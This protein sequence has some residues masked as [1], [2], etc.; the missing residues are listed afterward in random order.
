MLISLSWLKKYVRIPEDTRVLVDKLTMTGLNVERVLPTGFTDPNVVVGRVVGVSD[1]PNADKLRVCRVDAGG[2]APRDIVCG[3]ENVAEGQNVLVALPGAKLADGTRIK[4]AKIRGVRSDGMICSE[5]ELGLGDDAAG[6]MVLEGEYVPGAPVSEVLPPPDEILEIEVTPNRPD[7]LCH[8]GV[9]REVAAIERS[10]LELPKVKTSSS[11]GKAPFKVTIEKPEDCPRYVGKL[12]RGIRVGPSPMWLQSSLEGVGLNSV[13]NIVDVAN[14]VMLEMGQPL[15]AFDIKQIR[16]S[17]IVV[18]RARDGEALLALDGKNYELTA[19]TLVIADARQP[20]ALAGVIGGELS[21]VHGD[22]VDILIESANFDTTVVRRGRKG[23]GITTDASY[24]FER[25]VNRD[26]CLRAAERAADLICELAGGEAGPVVD[27]YPAPLAAKT[28]DIRRDRTRRILGADLTAAEIDEHLTALGFETVARS[29][30]KLSILVPSFRLDIEEEIDLIEEVARLYGYDQIGKAWKFR[31][32]T[33]AENPP[34][35]QFVEDL[36]DHMAARGYCEVATSSF[37][38]GREI[39]D[40]AWPEDDPRRTPIPIRNPLNVHHRYLRTSLLPGMLDVIRWNIDHGVRRL[41]LFQAG[42]V[43]LAPRGT[44]QLPEEQALLGLAVSYPNTADFWNNLK[45]APDLFDIKE[46]LEVFLRSFNIDFGAGLQYGFD[47]ATGQFRYR[48]KN[49]TLIEG[50]VVNEQVSRRYDFEQP[51][52]YASLDLVRLFQHHASQPRLRPIV[53]YPSSKRDLSLIAGQGVEFAQIEKS[54]VKTGGRL[55]ESAQVFDV[56]RGDKIASG[57]TAYGVR[58]TF[59]SSKGTL[60][61][62]EV[63][64]IIDKVLTRLK[65]E[66]KIELRT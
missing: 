13:N 19:E 2:K 36:C 15:H 57:H 50:G 53:D 8:V 27:A 48:F 7:L 34:Y 55:L 60:T 14:Y 43:F 30:D 63:D 65:N 46:E 52:W 45:L 54:L 58:L 51:V 12:V 44:T 23:L 31:T 25:G 10:P 1:H 20:V 28:I 16:D 5:R 3:A 39:E 35:D 6:I 4:Q 29:D 40:F 11:S 38:D 49:D 33:F 61:D 56:Y 64:Q 24:R 62:A 42:R 22:T 32:T 47:G 21:A 26:G 17:H 41:K 18:R 59:R 9:A 66:L 37:T